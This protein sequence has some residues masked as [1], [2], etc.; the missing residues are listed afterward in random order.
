MKYENL[1]GRLFRE[2]NMCLRYRIK[3]PV[4]DK[5]ERM[6]ELYLRLVKNCEEFCRGELFGS[7]KE[8]GAGYCYEL[9]VDAQ[10]K[11]GLLTLS[12]H[13]GLRHGSA[14]ISEYSRTLVY[15]PSDGMLMPPSALRKRL[16]KRG[17]KTGKKCE[18]K[19]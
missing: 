13:A 5:N 8:R 15:D 11:D 17:V 10:E 4:F 14:R 7:L 3:Y 12:L 1:N 16:K 18:K 6:N 2:G 9:S 19:C